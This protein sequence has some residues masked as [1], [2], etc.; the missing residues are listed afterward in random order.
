MRTL[1]SRRR[2]TPPLRALGE[3]GGILDENVDLT[4]PPRPERPL[5][6]NAGTSEDFPDFGAEVR[7][8]RPHPRMRRSRA[9]PRLV[10]SDR[11]PYRLRQAA[12]SE[13]QVE[14]TLDDQPL[15]LGQR[16]DPWLE[17]HVRARGDI[18]AKRVPV[19]P[20]SGDG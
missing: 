1:R 6:V 17:Q 13:A 4:E 8:L 20:V 7:A 15:S 2:P 18:G 3:R 16:E 11:A 10:A 14:E 19:D 12:V 9:M 5:D